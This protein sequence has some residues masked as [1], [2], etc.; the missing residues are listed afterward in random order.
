M[1][2]YFSCAPGG[3]YCPPA[4]EARRREARTTDSLTPTPPLS[5]EMKAKAKQ[6]AEEKLKKGVTAVTLPQ[7][8]KGKNVRVAG[9]VIAL[10]SIPAAVQQAVW[11]KC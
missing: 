1:T 11:K 10:A 9:F 2:A 4:R 8:K 3:R 6:K 7:Y 5:E